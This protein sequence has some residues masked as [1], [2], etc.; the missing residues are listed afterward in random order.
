MQNEAKKEWLKPMLEEL[1]IN[2]TMQGKSSKSQDGVQ[3]GDDSDNLG[4]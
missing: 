3:G 4:S 1:N 2:R